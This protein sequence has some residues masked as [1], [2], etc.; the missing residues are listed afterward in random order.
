MASS[1]GVL[2]HYAL[3]VQVPMDFQD[4]VRLKSEAAILSAVKT[5]AMSRKESQI[6]QSA[7]PTRPSMRA[8]GADDDS[9]LLKHRRKLLRSLIFSIIAPVLAFALLP[10]L[11]SS[12][13]EDFLYYRSASFQIIFAV[14]AGHYAVSAWEDFGCP[15]SAAS[16]SP[17]WEKLAIWPLGDCLRPSVVIS[18]RYVLE[19]LVGLGAVSVGLF[20]GRL[21]CLGIV[22]LFWEAPAAPFL[23]REICMAANE[24]PDWMQQMPYVMRF[25]QSSLAFWLTVR[26]L[27]SFYLVLCAVDMTTG[28]IGVTST[29]FEADASSTIMALSVL[30]AFATLNFFKVLHF[31]GQSDRAAIRFE[32]EEDARKQAVKVQNKWLAAHEGFFLVKAARSM[33]R[34]KSLTLESRSRSNVIDAPETKGGKHDKKLP[35]EEEEEEEDLTR[36]IPLCY[37]DE[38]PPVPKEKEVGITNSVTVASSPPLAEEELRCPLY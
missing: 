21:P 33:S 10:E 14:A 13:F 6:L 35:E 28:S 20:S 36:A 32:E 29:R 30:M 17:A 11:S 24:S 15:Y 37:V 26:P 2:L 22:C 9:G 27:L 25:W 3:P 7:K 4:A 16:I 34:T 23:F 1:F 8:V 38:L 5:R 12:R 31:T 19:S 18:T